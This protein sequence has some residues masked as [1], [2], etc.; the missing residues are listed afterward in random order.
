MTVV[1]SLDTL[2]GR[3]MRYRRGRPLETLMFVIGIHRHTLKK[4]ID[5]GNVSMEVLHTLEQWCADEAQRE[6]RLRHAADHN[7]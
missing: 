4:F 1:E 2:R 5:G 7:A 3:F 6:D